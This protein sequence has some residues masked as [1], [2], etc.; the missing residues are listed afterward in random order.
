MKNN[1]IVLFATILLLFPLIGNTCSMYK[2]TKNGRTIVGNNEDF[3]SPNNQFWFE[4][5]GDKKF[6][7]MYM[8]RI[9]NFAQGAINEAGLVF[10]GFA[11][12]ELAVTNTA[13]KTKISI[14]N[15][16]RNI[17]QSMATVEEV[18]VY[19]ETIDL[20]FL[21]SSML[22]FVDKSGTYL[23]VEGELLIIGEE[24]E[25]SFSNFYYSQINSLS[26]VNIPRF[27]KGQQF[28]NTTQGKASFDYCS[29]VMDNMKT[30]SSEVTST[31][32][33]TIYDL[34]SLKIRLYLYTDFSNYV[35]LDLKKELK[36]GNHKTMMIDLF[37]KDTNSIAYQFY[38]KYNDSNNPVLFLKEKMN[39]EQYSEEELKNKGVNW[40]INVVGYEW[41]K[42][43]KDPKTAIKV[44]KYGLKLMPNDFDL[45]DSLGEA[46]LDNKEWNK[47]IINYAKSL[48][49]NPENQNAIKKLLECKEK[50]ESFNSKNNNEN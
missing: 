46:Y 12:S 10:D 25:K 9:N 8:G 28:L 6:G 39:P 27:Q 3:L 45:Y 22:V 15:A 1:I 21:S 40:G 36:K 49:L 38:T 29:K 7:V 13:G 34:T 37:E 43:K 35:E 44:F 48:T 2:I 42:N 4:V 41:L 17:M 32:F 19:L 23:I 31:Q 18:K 30:E 11:N 26:E 50:K 16:L 24:S 5:A 14:V 47:A 20:S 33:S